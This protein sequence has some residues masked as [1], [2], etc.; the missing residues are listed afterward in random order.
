[1]APVVASVVSSFMPIIRSRDNVITC[2][3]MKVLDS[4]VQMDEL[5]GTLS[6]WQREIL[7]VFYTPEFFK[8]DEK[9]AKVS[10]RFTSDNHSNKAWSS[11]INAFMT[12]D[13][14][15][16]PD[17]LKM[18]SRGMARAPALFANKERENYN[19]ALHVKRLAFI[20]FSSAKDQYL[21]KLKTSCIH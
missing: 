14:S 15:I 18:F 21:G 6:A 17:F 9:Q 2:G 11:I 8:M 3:V 13:S 1:M 10:R 19:R 4:L 16:F 5:K 12:M 20:I 7:E